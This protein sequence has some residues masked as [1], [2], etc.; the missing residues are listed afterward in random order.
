[1]RAYQLCATTDRREGNSLSG[2]EGHP[3][4]Y[5]ALTRL[6]PW[7]S[8]ANLNPE[9]IG[10]FLSQE[11]SIHQHVRGQTIWCWF[12]RSLPNTMT[13]VYYEGELVE[14]NISWARLP[15]CLEFSG[16]VGHRAKCSYSFFFLFLFSCFFLEGPP[17]SLPIGSKERSA[18]EFLVNTPCSSW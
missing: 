9:F 13:M 3:L 6:W 14:Q 1:M 12:I 15:G 2:K 5:H 8:C 17:N 7:D 10:W 4:L 11:A 16:S 18:K